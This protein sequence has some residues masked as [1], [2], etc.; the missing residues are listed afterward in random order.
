MSVHPH[1]K[2]N[3]LSGVIFLAS[4]CLLLLSLISYDSMDPGLNVAAPHE[5]YSNYAGRIGALIADYLFELFGLAAFILPIPFI[6][7]GY[8]KVR[9]R[10]IH[11]PIVKLIGFTAIT[12]SV[13][14]GFSLLSPAL[15]ESVNFTPGGIFG[16][17]TSRQL[18]FYLNRPG[19]L[20]VI[21]AV[22]VS[23]LVLTTRF[24]LV[25]VADW[26]E[27]KDWRLSS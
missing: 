21:T 5:Q 11:S 3:E 9:G 18:L 15:P 10:P 2:L 17:L 27:K 12:F 26:I 24:S 20:I 7:V 25:G 19:S 1:S 23:A 14:A 8:K 13:C 22:L 16:I 6:F 4:S